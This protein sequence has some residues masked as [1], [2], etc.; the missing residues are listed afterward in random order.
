M[1]FRAL[2]IFTLVIAIG[3]VTASAPTQLAQ[4]LS[5][6]KTAIPASDANRVKT[7]ELDSRLMGRKMP[8]RVVLP[9]DY[10]EKDE[11]GRRYPV[12]Y[13]LH[14]LTGHF[15]NW[16]TKAKL[17]EHSAGM[18][19]IIVTPEGENGWYTDNLSKDKENYESYI[20]KELIPEIDRRYRTVA[21][22]DQRAIAGLSMGGY[23]SIKFGLKYP[24]MFV[25][26]GSFSGALGVAEITE[27]KF[28]GAVG[29][30]ID[31]IFGAEGSDIRK[32]NDPFDIIRRAAPEKIKSFPFVY[33]DCGTED[34]LFQ[35]N[36][37]FIQLLIEKK[38]PH[39]Y[40]QLPGAHNWE[41]WDKQVQ[42]FLEIADRTFGSGSAIAE[43][44]SGF[45]H[46]IAEITTTRS[47]RPITGLPTAGEQDKTVVTDATAAKMLLGRHMLSLQWI[48]WDYFGSATVKKSEGVYSIIGEQ[49]GRGNTDFLKIDGTIKSIDA[50]EFVF[51]G[52]IISQIS[53]I[54][55]GAPCR[56]EGEFTFKF[57]GKRKYWRL[58]QMDNP[59]DPVTDY[60][61]IYF[62]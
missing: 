1:K 27:K 25:L 57:T 29:K 36:R 20:V 7:E 4:T 41:Y 21:R 44:D 12:V 3:L 45:E 59:C 61:D 18:K 35:N 30:T 46:P 55:G 34:F 24:D 2:S 33:I 32:A 5:R 51:D 53:H 9:S 26:A 42:E 37:E 6:A 54:N 23:G 11:S 60:V 13:L 38:V 56:R 10:D 47:S 52:T 49:K 19:V 43:S 17:T 16:T 14:G 8:Y 39:E 31:A 58:M 62:K 28:P 50:K 48:S 22:R 40:R 15:D